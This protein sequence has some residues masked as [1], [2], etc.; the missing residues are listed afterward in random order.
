MQANVCGVGGGVSFGIPHSLFKEIVMNILDDFW[1][2]LRGRL[3]QFGYKADKWLDK[4]YRFKA[5]DNSDSK[6][7]PPVGDA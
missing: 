6:S 2:F 1:F 7:V 3:L 5:D 4:Y